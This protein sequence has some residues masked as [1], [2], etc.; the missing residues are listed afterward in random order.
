MPVSRVYRFCKAYLKSMRP[1]SFLITG[2]A[3]II[4]MIMARDIAPETV[5]LFEKGIIL[6]LLFSS[7]GINQVINDMMG[8]EED[9]INACNRPLVSGE[10]KFKW[11]LIIT[12]MIFLMGALLTAYLNPHALV[13]YFAAYLF[14][15]LYEHF[16][17]IPMLGNI[18]FG[19]LIAMAPLYGA[20]AS[21]DMN[22]LQLLQTYELLLVA[23]MVMLSAST[24]CFFT[25]FKDY[26]GD[27]AAGKMTIV[28]VIG[29]E[30]A[31][32]FGFVMVALPFVSVAAIFFT[33]LWSLSVGT[34]AFLVVLGTSA[35]FYL[36]AAGRLMKDIHD[37]KKHLERD[38]EAA[39]VF[40]CA[41]I[42]LF[43]PILGLILAIMVIVPTKFLFWWMYRK[44]SY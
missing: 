13:L 22:M 7:Y 10:L 35:F 8:M 11:C 44:R 2:T 24:M 41:L 6:A 33:D 36:K 30:R 39:G 9:R 31:K 12:I 34:L 17:G 20:M 16:K 1:Y 28:V 5:N 38:F 4:G 40:N 18:W 27:K 29:P 23:M 43:N 3:G 26:V 25:Y 14:N 21:T 15:I 19:V 37:K 42:A 32:W